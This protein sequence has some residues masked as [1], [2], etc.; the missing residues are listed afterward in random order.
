MALYTIAP[1]M[2]LSNL[3]PA[4]TLYIADILSNADTVADVERAM[5]GI[6]GLKLRK[7]QID[8]LS[9]PD[10][11]V[12]DEFEIGYCW[13]VHNWM[14]VVLHCLRERGLAKFVRESLPDDTIGLF[15]DLAGQGQRSR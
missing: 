2:L 7:I 4:E 10:Q 3:R 8:E 5:A 11:W 6:S 13:A 1:Y 14:H 15:D 9:E 12:Q